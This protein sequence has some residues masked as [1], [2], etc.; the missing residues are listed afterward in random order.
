MR[1]SR[2]ISFADAPFYTLIANPYP[3]IGTGN[4]THLC[5]FYG[6][7]HGYT[8]D[9]WIMKHCEE[10]RSLGFGGSL[11]K[12]SEWAENEFGGF[13]PYG[14]NILWLLITKYWHEFDG[15]FAGKW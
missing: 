11:E 13:A 12:Y 5:R 14:P 8:I 10:L 1:P 15:P 2:F 4:A 3:K 7:P 9:S 6:R